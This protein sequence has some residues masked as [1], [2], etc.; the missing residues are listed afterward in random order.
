MIS[1]FRRFLGWLGFPA[2]HEDD[3]D[4]ALE[5]LKRARVH[6][7]RYRQRRERATGNPVRDMVTGDYRSPRRQSHEA[8]SD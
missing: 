6:A 1:P 4:E 3:H 7:Q 8:T 5:Q 2:P